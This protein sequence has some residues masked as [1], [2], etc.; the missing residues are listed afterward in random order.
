MP[1]LW[2]LAVL[3]LQHPCRPL[4]SVMPRIRRFTAWY[5]GS[6]RNGDP[7]AALPG[8]HLNKLILFAFMLNP[9]VCLASLR[10]VYGGRDRP[11]G[12]R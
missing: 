12:P 9:R 3:L 5:R 4:L 10:M 2:S 1:H 7:A 6:V 8:G 11:T